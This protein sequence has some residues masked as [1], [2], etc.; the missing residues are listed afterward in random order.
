MGTTSHDSAEVINDRLASKHS[1]DDYYTKSIWPIRKIEQ[2]RLRIIS[3]MVSA[4]PGMKILEVGSGGGHVLR[5]FPQAKLTAVDVS[6]K[7]LETAR[8]NLKGYDCEFIKG[9]V[10]KLGL[11]EASFDRVICTEVLEHIDDFEPVLREISR[12]VSPTGRAVITVPNDPLINA[13]KK[14]V[15][16]SPVGWLLRERI[17][18]GGDH[19]HVHQWRP[20]QFRGVLARHFVVE[21][22]QSSPFEWLPI[23]ACFACRRRA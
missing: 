16:Y 14:V 2:G 9:E 6:G 7:F 17:E 13:G 10:D 18:A 19:F 8:Q 4:T 11:P 21:E 1:I 15:Q 23:R 20:S 5:L 12:L 22:Q 3:D